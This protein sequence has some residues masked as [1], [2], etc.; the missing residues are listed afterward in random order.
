MKFLRI[1]LTRVAQSSPIV[2]NK[3]LTF[4]YIDNRQVQRLTGPF[5]FGGIIISLILLTHSTKSPGRNLNSYVA[6]AEP[7]VKDTPRVVEQK[8]LLDT[9]DLSAQIIF[10]VSKISIYSGCRHFQCK[11]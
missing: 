2:G 7:S 11:N 1:T 10:D 3:W 5:G 8:V 6:L 9:Y 4:P